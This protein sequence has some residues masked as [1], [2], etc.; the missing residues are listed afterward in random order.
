VALVVIDEAHLLGED[1]GSVLE[2]IISRLNFISTH[3]GQHTR[4]VALATTVST[5][6]DLAAWLRVGDMGLY[7]FSPSARPVPL[8]VHINGY[9]GQNYCPRMATMNK[10]IYQAIRQH[11]TTQPVVIFVPSRRQTRLTALDL[12]ACLGLEDNPKQWVHKNDYVR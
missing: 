9:A 3:T 1:R 2:I 7:N 4:I 11:S 6:A 12:I 5:A 8:E 10:P